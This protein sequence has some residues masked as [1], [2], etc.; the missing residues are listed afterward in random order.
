MH[1]STGYVFDGKK[2]DKGKGYTEFDQPNPLNIYG[3]SKLEGLDSFIIYL[4]K[5]SL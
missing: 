4:Y 2:K 3:R 1:I 5:L